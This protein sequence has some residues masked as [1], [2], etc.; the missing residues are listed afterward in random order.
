M[1]LGAPSHTVVFTQRKAVLTVLYMKV[2]CVVYGFIGSI[3]STKAVKPYISKG[4]VEVPHLPI[5]YSRH[6]RTVAS[7]NLYKYTLNIRDFLYAKPRPKVPDTTAQLWQLAR[8][9]LERP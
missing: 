5:T 2:Y 4:V 6:I 8:E 7:R 9:P 3:G 1:G